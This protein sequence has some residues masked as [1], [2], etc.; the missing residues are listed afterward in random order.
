MN[1]IGD[2][3]SYILNSKE[4]IQTGGLIA[5]TLII[6]VENGLFFGFFLPGDY[7]LFLSGVFCSAKILDTPLSILLTCIF[8]ASVLGSLTGYL[9][10]RFF[11]ERIESKND[12]IFFKKRYIDKTRNYFEKY[13]MQTLIIARFLPIIRTFSPILAGIVDMKFLPFMV[14]NILG[15][16]IWTVVLV[17]G[18]F[19]L[20]EHFPWITNYVHYIVL[21]FLG[22]TTFTVVKGYLNAKKE[23]DEEE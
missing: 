13:G 20:G 18:G 11:G 16:L 8:L 23:I 6:F 10:G 3:F 1:E 17:G 12:S 19:Y 5:I 14:Y 7:L 4:I 15:G 22:I 2:F 9:S 21:F